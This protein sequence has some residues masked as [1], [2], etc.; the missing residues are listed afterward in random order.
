[1]LG[2]H[3]RDS[4][5][6]HGLIRRGV[7]IQRQR[8]RHRLGAAAP[9]IAGAARGDEA[10]LQHLSHRVPQRDEILTEGECINHG[11]H[12]HRTIQVRY[13]NLNRTTVAEN[14]ADPSTQISTIPPSSVSRVLLNSYQ[15]G[16]AEI[17]L[18]EGGIAEIAQRFADAWLLPSTLPRIEKQE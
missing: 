7:N 13:A 17:A 12:L 14:P 6:D 15:R 2:A 11:S 16:L 1:M 10:L 4:G 3:T 8:P 5:D 18:I 9:G